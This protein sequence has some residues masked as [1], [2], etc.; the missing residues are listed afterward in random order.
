[1]LHRLTTGG[2]TIGH[3]LYYLDSGANYLDGTTDMT[4]TLHFGQPTE[5]Q[6]ECYTLILRGILS[7]EMTAFQ[8]NDII[9]GY[10]IGALLQ[11]YFNARHYSSRHISFGHGV[12]HGQGVIEGGINISDVYSI[13]NEVPIK[14]GM[15]VTLEPRIYLEEQWG[16]RLENVYAV[17]EDENSWIHFKPLTLIPYSRRMIHFNQLTKQK[18]SWI[19]DYHQ[20]CLENVGRGLWMKNE[21]RTIFPNQ[22]NSL[23]DLFSSHDQLNKENSFLLFDR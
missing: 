7:V 10:R 6:M 18:I 14:A 23:V 19:T 16:I 15:V 17:E 5:K 2:K 22:C 8:S 12:S 1:M 20:R 21:I 9:T 11:Q 13:A 4:R 3:D